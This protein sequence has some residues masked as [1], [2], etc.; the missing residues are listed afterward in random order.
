M[1]GSPTEKAFIER[2]G[3]DEAVRFWAAANHHKN[4]I[5]DNNLGSD[6]FKWVLAICI[7]YQCA[8]EESYRK[9]HGITAPWE[10]VRQWI[11]DHGNLA[12]HDGDVDYI[13]V[14]TGVYSDFIP[15]EVQS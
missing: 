3:D 11:I 8:E 9:W 2:F 14:F 10:E 13:S 6:P 12:T 1:T 7:G 4:G 15:T 5:N